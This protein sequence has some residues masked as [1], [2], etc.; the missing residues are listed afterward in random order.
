MKK[1]E[2]K[3]KTKN[4]GLKRKKILEKEGKRNEEKVKKKDIR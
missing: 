4:V 3:R 2:K 1:K